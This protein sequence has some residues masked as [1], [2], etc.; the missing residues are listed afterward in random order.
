MRGDVFEKNAKV[1]YEVAAPAEPGGQLGAVNLCMMCGRGCGKVVV[2][3]IEGEAW[4]A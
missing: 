4:E 1:E 3:R 2:K